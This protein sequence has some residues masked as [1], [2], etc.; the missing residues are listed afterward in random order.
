MKPRYVALYVTTYKKRESRRRIVLL[1]AFALLSFSILTFPFWESQ[2]STAH[3]TSVIFL[4]TP[5]PRPKP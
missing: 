1:L 2:K 3:N 5:T 4:A